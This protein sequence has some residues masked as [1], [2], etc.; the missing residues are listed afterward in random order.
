MYT[1][2]YFHERALARSVFTDE[3]QHFSPVDMQVYGVECAH[4]GERFAD[5]TCL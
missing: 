2:E 5:P 1:G 3:G 4:A